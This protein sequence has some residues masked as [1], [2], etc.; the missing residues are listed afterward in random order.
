MSE[1]PT[2]KVSQPYKN[3]ADVLPK[4]LLREVQRYHGGMLWVPIVAPFHKR[5]NDLIQR[6]R[7]S[8]V[9]VAEIAG[10]CKVS[11]RRIRQILQSLKHSEE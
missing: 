1:T 4:A 3:A 6:L 11:E 5:R 2:S 8:G 9:T 7:A 10:L